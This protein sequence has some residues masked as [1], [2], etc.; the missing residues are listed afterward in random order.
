MSAILGSSNAHLRLKYTKIIT[1]PL[2]FILNT[3]LKV[4]KN[5]GK[6]D[7]YEN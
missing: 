6:A 4:S 5:L 3:D 1:V 2:L 7:R